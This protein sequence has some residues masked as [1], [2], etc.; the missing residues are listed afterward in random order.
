[1]QTPILQSWLSSTP[2]SSAACSIV[3]PGPTSNTTRPVSVSI[4]TRC[5]R[6]PLC[7]R[8]WLLLLVVKPRWAENAGKSPA[9]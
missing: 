4:S 8:L 2:W 5:A 1:M 6:R 7:G 3:S 9:L